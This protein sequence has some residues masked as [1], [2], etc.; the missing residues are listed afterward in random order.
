MKIGKKIERPK[1]VYCFKMQFWDDETCFSFG[2]TLFYKEHEELK[3]FVLLLENCKV[4]NNPAEVKDFEYF[5]GDSDIYIPWPRLS[6]GLAN[7]TDYEVTYFNENG[8]EFEVN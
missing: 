8:E 6:D 5:T 3:R 1:N 2:D 4:L 7:L